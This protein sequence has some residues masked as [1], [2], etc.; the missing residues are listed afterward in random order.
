MI[1]LFGPLVNILAGYYA[2]SMI[3][4]DGQS[5]GRVLF[6]LLVLPI[7]QAVGADF[8]PPSEPQ[9]IL[10]LDQLRIGM[11]GYGLTVFRGAR[12][13]PFPIE[14]VSISRDDRPK[15]GLIW[16]L[17]PGPR[18]QHSGPVSGMSGSPIYVWEDG[19][20]HELGKGGKLIGAFALG[21]S[22]VKTC[23]AGVQPIEQMREVGQHAL[24]QQSPI[25]AATGLNAGAVLRRLLETAR[26]EG[27]SHAQTWRLELLDSL[28]DSDHR[29]VRPLPPSIPP[30]LPRLEGQ[31]KPL[32]LPVS[33]G[34]EQLSRIF[35]PLMAPMG[36]MPVSAGP[37]TGKPPPGVDTQDIRLEPGSVLAIPFMWGDM[38]L[39]ATGTC[40]EVLPDGR[41]LAFGHQMFAQGPIALPLATGYVH[42]IVPRLTTSFKLGGSAVLQ[43][44]AI[45]RDELSAVASTTTGTYA[46]ASMTVNI[47]YPDE[48]A[49]QYN[50]TMV[51][52][53]D[54]TPMLAAMAAIQSMTAE[55]D[56]PWDNTVRVTGTLRF[57]SD[58]ELRINSVM[59]GSSAT[60]IAFELLGPLSVMANNEFE[61]PT[62]VQH[63]QITATIEAVDRRT[64][65]THARPDKLEYA[66]GESV[67]I[68]VEHQPF[69]RPRQSLRVTLPLPAALP[70]GTYTVRVASAATYAQ[71]LFRNRPHLRYAESTADLLA[72]MR[73]LY[74]VENDALYV[75]MDTP[76]PGLA[77]RR[78]ELPNLPSSRRALVT[79]PTS[80]M[81]SRFVEWIE[82]KIRLD[83]IPEGEVAI[84]I[85]VRNDLIK[86]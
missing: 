67:G 60:A 82:K 3:R 63:V 38:D 9:P 47:H 12:I 35:A 40:T 32:M 46:T 20:E 69:R 16:I 7:G 65:L 33:V 2:L 54:F 10:A 8:E 83:A 14:I 62:M 79:A 51:H 41:T 28:I 53:R 34:S 37:V 66:P 30:P 27:L 45:V 24:E 85:S 6:A 1:R 80:P 58:Q 61:Q 36:F 73:H 49:Q 21:Y 72:T 59:A 39:P 84:R 22:H 68:T 70:D 11:K 57:D 5:L 71:R 42:M 52:H 13:E 25:E 15:K 74:R 76:K 64:V 4:I 75:L 31:V 26:R 17:C 77:L 19:E 44:G 78:H 23:Y 86:S 55:R 81:T 48:P 29:E 43:P 56:L 18:M 50:Y